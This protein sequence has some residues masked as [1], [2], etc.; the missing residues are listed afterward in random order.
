MLFR[1][2]LSMVG[3]PMLAG[4]IAKMLF[5]TAAVE[6]GDIKTLSTL[7]VLAISTV[8]NAVY[9]LHTVIRIYTPVNEPEEFHGIHIRPKMGVALAL[10]CLV[11]L[12]FVLGLMSQPI[13][14]LIEQGIHMFA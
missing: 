1:S 13:T 11:V 8:L 3:I 10:L 12:N 6:V 4:F 9:F 14:D 2:S 7:I 5:A